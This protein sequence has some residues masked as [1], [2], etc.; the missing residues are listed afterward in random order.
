TFS[1]D[2]SSDVCSSDLGP[3]NWSDES[4]RATVISRV[5][6]RTKDMVRNIPGNGLGFG[7]LKYLAPSSESPGP[8]LSELP[9]PEI[10]FNYLGRMR[11]GSS[12]EEDDWDLIGEIGRASCRER[13]ERGVWAG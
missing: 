13:G 3:L 8:D 7:L 11:V 2:W 9:A 4:A 10:G 5:I 6:K 12:R 1:R